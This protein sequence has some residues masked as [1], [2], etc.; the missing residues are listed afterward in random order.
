M[1]AVCG[2]VLACGLAGA[3]PGPGLVVVLCPSSSGSRSAG[4]LVWC[5]CLPRAALGPNHLAPVAIL[6][7]LCFSYFVYPSGPGYA[8]FLSWK[9]LWVAE[10]NK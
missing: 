8:A 4:S 7:L 9:I 6:L 3:F 2:V 10:R 1:W 5:P